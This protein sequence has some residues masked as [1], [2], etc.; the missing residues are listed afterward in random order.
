MKDHI[1][2]YKTKLERAICEYMNNP[3]TERSTEAIK[4]MVKCWEHV[5]NME[6]TLDYAEK[7]TCADAMAWNK[8]M[9]NEDGTT[10]GHWTCEQTS[11]VAESIGVN[12]EHITDYCFNV[13]MNMMY[14]DYFDVAEK[15]GVNS[16]DFY[17]YMAKAFLFDRDGGKPK[18]KLS[19]YYFNI[20]KGE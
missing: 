13:T 12:F 4:T 10:G 11:A 5:N 9:L 14:S 7:F 17:G 1:N 18:E 19:E 6:R 2:E 3:V 15:Y 20:V 8:G 16:P